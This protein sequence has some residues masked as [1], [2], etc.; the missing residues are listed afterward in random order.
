MPGPP[1][2]PA[3][4]PGIAAPPVRA[5]S[6]GPLIIGLIGGLLALCLLGVCGVAVAAVVIN[7]GEDSPQATAG[8]VTPPPEEVRTTAPAPP[9]SPTPPPP[10]V[11][12]GQC[13]AV[14]AAGNLLGIG[15]CNGSSGTYRVVS[16]DY[17]R[18]PCADPGGPY[19]TE[20]GYR[21]CL[22]HHLVRYFCYK[23][24]KGDGWVVHAPKCKAKGTVHVIDIVPGAS[25]GNKCTRD[26][27]WNRWYRFTHP[28]VVYCVMQ[29]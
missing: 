5:K 3:P 4:P 28:T 2:P 12:I 11:A 21:L 6:N 13:V 7:K 24:P 23:F 17:G 20:D 25:N 10:P 22:E 9:P 16:V 26:L 19:I 18:N 15:N 14:D 27:R 1:G 8:G 29:Y